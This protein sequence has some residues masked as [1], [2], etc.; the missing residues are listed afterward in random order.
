MKCDRPSFG[1]SR[2]RYEAWGILFIL[3]HMKQGRWLLVLVFAGLLYLVYLG[4]GTSS[5]GERPGAGT[6]KTQSRSR[7]AEQRDPAAS[8]DRE[9]LNRKA[10]SVIYSKH[11][12]CRMSCRHISEEEVLDILHTGKINYGK[13]DMRGSPDP[14]YALEGGTKD[15]QEVRI[16]FASSPRGIVVVT[17]IDID[18]EWKC[19]CK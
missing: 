12:R 7:R 5:R 14:K 13:S 16:I 1:H 9:G 3:A 10:A 8:G 18:K 2:Q 6:E 15:G 17:V 11:A 19:N 4:Q